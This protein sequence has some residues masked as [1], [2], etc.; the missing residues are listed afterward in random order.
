MET[1][2][3]RDGPFQ[4]DPNAGIPPFQLPVATK[5]RHHTT[6]DQR[7]DIKMAS[8]CGLTEHQIVKQMQSNGYTLT[9]R[10]VRYALQQPD[11]PKKRVGRPQILT[12]DQREELVEFVCSSKQGRRMTYEQLAKHFAWWEVKKDG[13]RAA[14]EREGF[15]RRVAMCKPPISEKNRKLRLQFALEH[16]G[17][18]LENWCRI[19]WSDETW[20]TD[21]R[22]KRTFITRR[23]G[24]EWDENCIVEKVRRKK[25]WM[26]WGSFHGNIRGPGFF[27]E[28]D[29]G[30]ISGPTYREHTVPVIAQYLA[31]IGG[32]LG[33]PREL[34][35]M[36]DNA[37]GHSA[38]DTQEL[39]KEYAIHT[40]PWPPF[41]PDLNPI[42]TLWRHM[43]E[44]LTV[45]Y[46]D[47]QFQTYEVSRA[48]V[49]EAWDHVATSGMLQELIESMPARMEAVIAANGKFTK[50]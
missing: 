12:R 28:K 21:G 31:D 9:V 7:R 37:P 20:V 33:E 50:Y 22:H 11:T 48:K 8:R 32:L 6:R 38:K 1:I 26:F 15:H 46:G 14:L 27:W 16:R 30:T 40:I 13:I 42:E 5:H 10:Q 29:W 23:P 45:K 17:W 49:Q 44:Y 43:K 41:S 25:G 36:Q 2:R 39:L 3:N 34:L 19:L 4:W 24:E 18:T 35:F 47:Y